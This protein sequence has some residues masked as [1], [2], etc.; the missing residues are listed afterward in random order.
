MSTQAFTRAARIAAVE[1][2]EIV[3]I[4][5]AARARR[6]AGEDVI[7]LSTGEP[8]FDT[9]EHVKAAA[10]Q[11]LR[12]N[13]THYPPTAG[14]VA[15]KAAVVRKFAREN[16]LH[17]D[18]REVIV[19]T[20]AK[21]V[22]F[23]AFMATLNPGDEVLVPAP[24]WTS[25]GDMIRITGAR[26]VAV[27]CSQE[28]GFRLTPEA[29]RAAITPRTRWL[30]LNSPSN[31]SG[32]A[33]DADAYRALAAVLTEHPRIWVAAD[34]IY[35]HLVYGDFTFTA[36]RAA[37]AESAPEVAARTLTVNGVSKAYA[38]TGWRLGYGAGDPQL[39]TAMTAVQGQVTSGASTISQA[40]AVAALDGP[41]DAVRTFRD[42]FRTRRDS[43]VAALNQ[44]P[45]LDCPTPEGAFYVF[46]SC[47][48]LIGSRTPDGTV[49]DGDGAFC[50]YLLAAVG[51]AVVPGG[52]FGSPGHFRISYA[53]APDL[54]EE[55][56]RR[57]ATACSELRR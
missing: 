28:Q 36:F 50:H 48:G 27:P 38:M 53:T 16:D 30:L 44:C 12:D 18:P 49:I 43:I 23:N 15:L 31:P 46:P 24:F 35:E 52:P 14:T 33:Y 39:V 13:D 25:Y 21:Q 37:V 10:E 51:V 8:D 41:Q 22:L 29:L 47:A 1:V 7:G 54:L 19:S 57:I 45:G 3:R 6:A 34:E 32:A 4:A 9:P 55:A 40:A 42:S 5:E 17:F 2:S 56:G 26:V 11:A 20:G